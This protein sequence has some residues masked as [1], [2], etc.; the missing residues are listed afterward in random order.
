MKRAL[1]DLAAPPFCGHLHPVLG[2]ARR[3]AQD[4]DV[5]LLTTER[6]MARAGGGLEGVIL[7]PDRDEE[8]GAIVDGSRPTRCNPFA[9][10]AQLRANLSLMK[11][12]RE[13]ITTLY[14]RRPPDLLIA[15]LTL[16][17]LGAVAQAQG[18]PWW[19]SHPSP[20]VAEAWH[21]QGTP[22]YLGGLSPRSDPLGRG[23]DLLGHGLTRLFKRAVHAL[24]RREFAALGFPCVY[25]PDGTEAVY[26]PERVLGLSWPELE[27][28][29]VWPPAFH[30]I[31]PVLY[32][33]PGPEP[34][35]QFVPGKR[36]VLVTFGTHLGW[37]KDRAAEAVNHAA[38]MLP[39]N[40][41]HFSEGRPEGNDCGRA[42]PVNF[43]RV[44]YVS[45]ERHL[46]KYDL[47]V[48]HGGAGIL[49]WC[50]RHGTPTVVFPVDYDQFD[51]AARLVRAGLSRRLRAL[52]ELAF[53]VRDA[54]AD[55]RLRERCA[56]FR[57]MI[58]AATP[59]V[60]LVAAMV[61]ARLRR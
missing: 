24:H 14:R 29:R 41:F 20:C 9:L 51:Y 39:E 6:G 26:S 13:Q 22:A 11:P 36:H 16:P 12:L 37:L 7:L 33:P 40:I 42:G 46:S 23:R 43:Q 55:A 15:D 5:R 17:V 35:L 49:H 44:A 28:P 60:E 32:S 50:L 56:T 2:M 47:V 34:D 3:L 10:H 54:L 27:F 61:R 8:I 21:G 4:Y 25:R 59:P 30:L 58:S 48:H 45:Y 53:T 38:R 18:V 1:I 57:R 19:T 31:G 52:S